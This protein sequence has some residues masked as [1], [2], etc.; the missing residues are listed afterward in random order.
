MFVSC[1]RQSLMGPVI[2]SVTLGRVLCDASPWDFLIKYSRIWHPRHVSVAPYYSVVCLVHNTSG[3]AH[4]NH[5]AGAAINA[6][7]TT[8]GKCAK[9]C[10]LVT[11]AFRS[12]QRQLFIQTPT[13]HRSQRISLT[14]SLK[15]CK[16]RINDMLTF[17]NFSKLDVTAKKVCI[18]HA[19]FVF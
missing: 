17:K 7:I 11:R 2:R 9:L 14:G 3:V 18:A 19:M 6:T 8:N 15:K 13:S 12:Q 10:V 5:S 16:T 4:C 1:C